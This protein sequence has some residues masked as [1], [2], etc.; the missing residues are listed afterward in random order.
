MGTIY[1]VRHRLLDE[2]RAIKVMQPHVVGDAEMRRRFQEEARTAT[3]LKHPHLCVLYDFALDSDGTAY[4]VMEYIEGVNLADFLKS[5]GSPGIP[6]S[7]EIAH[8]ALLALGYLHR[9]GVVHRDVAPDNLMLSSD[10][11]GR[12]FV[13]VID[14]GIAKEMDRTAELTASGVFL[15]KLRYAS[16][17]Q[18]GTL[19]PGQKLDGRSDLYGLGIVLYELLTGIR[20]FPGESAAELLRAHLMSTP[21][22]FSES[23]PEGKVPPELRAIVLKALEKN[24][25]DRFASAEEMDREIAVLRPRLSRPGDLDHTRTMLAGVSSSPGLGSGV[26]PSAQDRLDRQF[27]DHTTPHPTPSRATAVPPRATAASEHEKTTAA[28]TQVPPDQRDTAPLSR[29]KVRRAVLSLALLAVT[30]LGAAF[31]LWFPMSRQGAAPRAASL[32]SPRSAATPGSSTATSPASASP[33]ASASKPSVERTTEQA[34]EP[35]R[36]A[37]VSPAAE[38]VPPAALEA[39]RSAALSA[40][41]SAARARQAALRAG[42]SEL[43][44]AL[45]EVGSHKEKEAERQLAAEDWP[46]ARAGFEAAA[47]DYTGAISWIA[48]HPRKPSAPPERIAAVPGPTLPPQPTAHLEPTPAAAAP[49]PSPV[50]PRAPT[51]PPTEAPRVAPTD[52]D[53]IRAVLRDFERAQDTL[54]LDLY[55]RLYPSLSSAQ[56]Q[57]LE[58]A[59]QGLAKQQ[60]ELDIRQIDV[61]GSHAVARVFQRLVAVPR[62]GSELRDAR[63]RTFQLEKHGEAWVITGLD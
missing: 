9:K 11:E 7:L 26:T 18:Y 27:A 2:I 46:R 60:V 14:L 13:K 55:T 21:V 50:P 6:T 53:R 44:G 59:W 12:L 62:I 47:A 1:R 22:P 38:L 5:K 34:V 3:R 25:D 39:S 43:A 19:A 58:R 42:A 54:D 61:K 35:A 24:R 30:I 49:M 56:R 48:S 52:A 23:D 8:Q 28:P 10:E 20:P 17:E 16:P 51:S 33:T 15:G 41:A 57:N 37:E 63:E 36:P 31:L 29:P 45:F 40:R 32:P 4:L